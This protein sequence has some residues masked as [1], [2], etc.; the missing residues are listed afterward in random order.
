MGQQ[1]KDDDVQQAHDHVFRDGRTAPEQRL[2]PGMSD[3][4]FQALTLAF[5]GVVGKDNVHTGEALLDFSD[6]FTLGTDNFPSAAVC[7]K[8]V[9]EIRAILTLVNQ[10]K[11]PLWV[12]SRGKNLGYGVLCL[13]R[14][15]RILE[16]NEKDAYAVVEPGVT[17]FDLYQYCRD[18][19]LSLWPS[20]P[21]IAWGSVVGNTLDRGF[22][23]TAHGDHQNYICG[24]EVILPD[25][26]TLRTGQWA[27]DNSPSAFACKTNLGPQLDG[28][29]LQS[30]LGIVTKLGIWVQPQPE[31]TMTVRLELEEPEDLTQLVEIFA[32]LRREDVLQNDPA[33]FNVLRRIGRLGPRH[34]IYPG[35][36]AI[37]DDLIRKIMAEKGWGYWLA[38]FSFYGTRDMVLSR[39]HIA[40]EAVRR[41]FPSGARL[42][43][44]LFEGDAE[45]ERVDATTIPPEWQPMNAG[46][47]S[48]RYSSTI[49]FNTPPGGYGGHMDLSPIFP[50]DGDLVWKWY[51]VVCEVSHCFGFDSFVGGHAFNKHC[52]LV[53]MIMFN[54][55]DEKQMR[56]AKELWHE[57][58]VRAK[59]FGLATYRTHLDYMDLMQDS[60][61]F[62]NNA[63]KRFVETIKDAMDPNGILSPGKSGIW[64][65]R[66]RVE[67][68]PGA[69][70]CVSQIVISY[71][72]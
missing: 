33:F 34:E 68:D 71:V 1:Y 57:L 11:T 62:N 24:M 21:S 72:V 69:T 31:T 30:N 37:P 28:L 44:Q 12:V 59:E 54:R 15:D 61:G 32:E 35:P 16:V 64:P 7:P 65:K 46:V 9:D 19:K 45:G 5:Q 22:G 38:Y 41:R 39:L 6:P 66:Y 47:P 42:T 8:T 43:W 17:F 29:F 20:V 10:S 63:Q 53:H 18:R 51:S 58:A 52:V 49:D 2:P 55:M 56:S 23:Y 67:R 4:Q 60:Y 50:L 26:D 14:M 13:Y 27:V 3:G 25:G 36:G 70:S 48:L 40:E